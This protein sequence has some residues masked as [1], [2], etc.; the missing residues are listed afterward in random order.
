MKPNLTK[1]AFGLFAIAAFSL[2]ACGD[3]D[4]EGDPAIDPTF[5]DCVLTQIKDDDGNQTN[6]TYNA[7]G[8][9]TTITNEVT[10]D[11]DYSS[12]TVTY[13]YDSNNR[14]I[15]QEYR[16][17]DEDA[18]YTIYTYE[19]GLVSK[20]ENYRDDALVSTENFIYDLDDRVVK[21]TDS[22]GNV[23]EFTYNSDGNIT[24]IRRTEGAEIYLT[25]YDEYDK[26]KTPYTAVKGYLHPTAYSVNNPKYRKTYQVVNG[27]EV[28]LIESGSFLDYNSLGLPKRI[29]ENRENGWWQSITN[30]TYECK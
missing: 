21:V 7:Q 4:D 17:D 19:G 14:V 10:S 5:T 16:E 24:E 28:V 30:L 27:E 15:K 23:T 29:I 25:V 18:G 8:Y 9:V 26:M 3:S 22:D 12:R 11:F 6:F 13:I 1:A 20:S 2:T